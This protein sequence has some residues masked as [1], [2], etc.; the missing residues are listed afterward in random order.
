MFISEVKQDIAQRVQE[1]LEEYLDHYEMQGAPIKFILHVDG[2]DPL[3]WANIQESADAWRQVPE[4]LR[5]NLRENH[6][7]A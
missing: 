7:Y 6:E 2:N 4:S 3:S 5:G 1:I